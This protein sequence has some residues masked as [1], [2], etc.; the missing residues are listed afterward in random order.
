LRIGDTIITDIERTA[1]AITKGPACRIQLTKDACMS[2]TTNQARSPLILIVD[3]EVGARQLLRYILERRGYAVEEADDGLQALAAYKRSRPDVVLLDV[4][5][6][7]MDGFTACAEIRAL[8]GGNH[9][10]VII[11]TALQSPEAFKRASEAGATD[12]MIKPADPEELCHRLHALLH[13]RQVE[14]I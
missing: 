3:D 8:P 11:V 1:L 5:M 2:R 7:R 12:Y 4:M 9:T 10:P 13:P 6:P 14:S